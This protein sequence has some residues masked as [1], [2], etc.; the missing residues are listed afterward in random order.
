MLVELA[1][2]PTESVERTKSLEK[3][4]TKVVVQ[5]DVSDNSAQKGLPKHLL[6]DTCTLTT[7][8]HDMCCFRCFLS[9]REPFIVNSCG[10]VRKEE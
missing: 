10:K 9:N 5:S 8:K 2:V 6:S 7:K 1:E 3:K 4:A